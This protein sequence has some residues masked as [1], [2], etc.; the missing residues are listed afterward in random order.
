MAQSE[1]SEELEPTLTAPERLQLLLP[2]INGDGL[3]TALVRERLWRFLE[4]HT[5]AYG[6]GLEARGYTRTLRPSIN[7]EL[8]GRDSK[9]RLNLSRLRQD[10]RALMNGTLD[11]RFPSLRFA[12]Q[13]WPSGSGQYVVAVDG[14]VRDVVLYQVMRLLT[15]PGMV[16]LARCPAPA[17]NDWSRT[18]GNWL[19]TRGRH[20]GRPS[21]YC[22]MKCR[23]RFKRK[24]DA[25]RDSQFRHAR[26]GALRK[27]K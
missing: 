20:R 6:S 3:A 2:W 22:S 4:P 11:H 14:R 18:C 17:P 21:T 27:A 10:L 25:E 15:A 5:G 26:R 1:T 13:H 16:V 7:S 9:R 24:A 8:F 12:V 19:V 23:V